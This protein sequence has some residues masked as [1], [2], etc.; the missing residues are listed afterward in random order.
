M[1]IRG[2]PISDG[3]AVAPVGRQGEIERLI[4]RAG[5]R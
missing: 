2:I 1:T 3:V 5:K 4:E